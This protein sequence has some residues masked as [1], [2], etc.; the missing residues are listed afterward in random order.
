MGTAGER[1][2][3]NALKFVQAREVDS[4]EGVATDE[5]LII[6]P[7]NCSEIGAPPIELD[8]AVGEAVILNPHSQRTRTKLLFD[9]FFN[10]Q[11]LD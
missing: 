10:Y 9:V 5:G 6:P 3:R 8:G 7:P 11:F 2:L 4:K 1:H